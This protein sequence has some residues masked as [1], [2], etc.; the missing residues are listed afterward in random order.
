MEEICEVRAS[1]LFRL[2]DLV[3][4]FFHV[5]V[6]DRADSDFVV[7]AVVEVPQHKEKFLGRG[8]AKKLE[9]DLENDSE[10]PVVGGAIP[11]DVRGPHVDEK[12]IS[13]RQGKERR[14]LFEG[15]ALLASLLAIGALDIEDE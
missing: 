6:D 11:A 14:G 12:H 13:H 1:V 15:H 2:V 8:L 7:A 4:D 3:P 10:Q 5:G 9:V